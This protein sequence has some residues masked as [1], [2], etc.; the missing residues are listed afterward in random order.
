MNDQLTNQLRNR[1]AASLL[2]EARDSL[3]RAVRDLTVG[4]GSPVVE[5]T[6]PADQPHHG[7]SSA[8]EIVE[9]ARDCFW[10]SVARSY[11]EATGR[12]L[13]PHALQVFDEATACA[14]HAWVELNT[15]RP[16]QRQRLVIEIVGDNPE[17]ATEMLAKAVSRINKMRPGG[18]IVISARTE[19]A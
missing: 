6:E 17:F 12:N 11:P 2:S 9:Y 8:E 1:A 14:T 15:P 19:Q 3:E 18:D 4:S 16:R 10:T 7:R 5:A 13:P